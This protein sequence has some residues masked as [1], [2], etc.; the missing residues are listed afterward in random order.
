MPDGSN[1]RTQEI[2][3]RIDRQVSGAIAF[4]SPGTALT[5]APQ[6]M[7]EM[8]E[9]AKL[10]AMSGP[11]VRPAFRGKP[12]ACLAIALQAFRT[13][14][15]PFAV[16]N[17][18]YI[19]TSRSGDEQIAY[20]AQYIH[21]V[22]NTSGKL[23]RRL[24]PIYS[25]EGTKRRCKIVGY[26]V[27]EEEPLDYESPAIDEIPVKNSPLWKGDPDQQLFYY[28]AR[29]WGRRHLPEVLLGMYTPDEI[30]GQ[31]IDVTPP[32]RPRPEDY[33][34]E[35]VNDPASE[36]DEPPA[37]YEAVDSVGETHEYATEDEAIEALVGW[38]AEVQRLSELDALIENNQSL[39]GPAIIDAHKAKIEQLIN[40]GSG[41]RGPGGPGTAQPEATEQQAPTSNPPV[42]LT[43]PIRKPVGKSTD[44]NGTAE[45]WIAAIKKLANPDD[46]T[47]HGGFVQANGR[48]LDSMK[49]SNKAAWGS[50][51]HALSERALE[52]RGSGP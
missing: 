32:A 31:V 39:A 14:A 3:K 43:V 15:D 49:L 16:A 17:K 13:G 7:A 26:V 22:L 44:W 19:T 51:I 36:E 40:L 9:F 30:T 11:C 50:V 20:E 1:D 46:V 47:P 52:L 34:E 45:D 21:A 35:P 12:G 29:A 6:N 8:F 2:E 24:R 41:P 23:S 28:S 4:S 37:T 18:A 25:G 48:N 5:I 38:I 42:S 33:G 27:G 10:M